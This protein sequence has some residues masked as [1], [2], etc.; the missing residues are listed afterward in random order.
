M[1]WG[2]LAFGGSDD[3]WQRGRYRPS[4]GFGYHLDLLVMVLK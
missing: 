2:K 1:A 4:D 3:D